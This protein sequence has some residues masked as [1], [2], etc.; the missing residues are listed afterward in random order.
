MLPFFREEGML[1]PTDII[2]D[3]TEMPFSMIVTWQ[4]SILQAVD[5]LYG[6]K[7]VSTFKCGLPCPVY[8]FKANKEKLGIVNLPIGAPVAAG[9]MEEYIIRGV[10][11]FV[12]IGYAGTLSPNAGGKIIV[13]TQAYRDEGTSWHYAPHDSP[14]INVNTAKKLDDILTELDIPHICGRVWTTDAF[15]R[16]TPSAVRM[17]KEQNCLCVDMECAA[18]MAVAQMRNVHCYQMMFGADSLEGDSWKRGKLGRGI[19]SDTWATYAQIAIQVA[20]A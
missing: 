3:K 7:Q 20:Q 16:E 19:G 14:W 9:F 4:R 12:C 10:M 13:P 1:K 17:M 2:R 5:R 6:L 11:Q 8:E 15:Y 18:N